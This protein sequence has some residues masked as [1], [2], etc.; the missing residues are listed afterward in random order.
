MLWNIIKILLKFITLLSWSR[1][2]PIRHK[3]SFSQKITFSDALLNWGVSKKSFS[4]CTWLMSHSNFFLF[5]RGQK[6]MKWT[7]V[8]SDDFK[9]TPSSHFLKSPLEGRQREEEKS[10]QPEK[11]TGELLIPRQKSSH[12]DDD[13]RGQRRI[14]GSCPLQFLLFG[15]NPAQKSKY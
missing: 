6:K 11:K 9:E 2:S 14:K 15:S 13:S 4:W 10:L 12:K 5:V 8:S 3:K 1:Q 7:S